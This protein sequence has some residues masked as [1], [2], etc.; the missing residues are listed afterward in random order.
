MFQQDV[1][2][3]HEKLWLPKTAAFTRKQQQNTHTHTHTHTK[4][5]LYTHTHIH[6]H[7]HTQA[8]IRTDGFLRWQTN[9]TVI[10]PK[11]QLMKQ[12]PTSWQLTGLKTPANW[13]TCNLS[14]T[15]TFPSEHLPYNQHIQNKCPLLHHVLFVIVVPYY[16]FT[17]KWGHKNKLP[18][19]KGKQK[20][21]TPPCNSFHET[22][23]IA[24]LDHPHSRSH[25]TPPITGLDHP[26]SGSHEST[27]VTD[28]MR[29]PP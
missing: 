22:I 6:K 16:L 7:T 12:L 24:G 29:P 2:I 19:W 4:C 21:E 28:F 15:H 14:M 23:P 18:P 13:L 3:N 8:N 17:H 27:P 11:H 20:P 25:E 5:S 26:H 1:G 10:Q 9:F